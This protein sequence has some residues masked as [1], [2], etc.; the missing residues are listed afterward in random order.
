MD[1]LIIVSPNMN[2]DLYLS[3]PLD[4]S[5]KGHFLWFINSTGDLHYTS[6]W[7]PLGMFPSVLLK[8][9]EWESRDS[10]RDNEEERDKFAE[11]KKRGRD[12][13]KNNFNKICTDTR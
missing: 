8:S 11:V 9:H 12:K 5:T 1:E 2:R 13:G 3:F 6:Y 10:K 7:K 4:L